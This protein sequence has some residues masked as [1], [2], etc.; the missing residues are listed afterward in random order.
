VRLTSLTLEQFRNY[1]SLS[2]ELA[3]SR[4]HL[5][6]G[7][8]GSGKTNVLEAV[9]ILSIA[10]SCRGR[11]DDEIATWGSTHYRVR[12]GIMADDGKTGTLEAVSELA[13]RRRKAFFRNDAKAS[14][15]SIVGHL[16]TVIF[17]PQDLILFS[18]S[19]GDRRRFLDQLLCQVSPEYLA[20]FSAYQ[21]LLQQR[22]ALLRR[23]A[24]GEEAEDALVPWDRELARHGGA[25]TRT[26]LELVETLN[27]SL[28]D[29][30][31]SLGESWPD[32][33]IVYERKGT[34]RDQSAM[35]AEL[36]EL[37]SRHRRRDLA[38][39]STGVGPHRED[40]QLIADGRQLPSFASRGQ[41]RAAVLALL[42]LEVSYLELRRG[43]RP[44]ILLDDALSE[45]DDAHQKALMGALKSYQVLLTSA[46]MPPSLP[47]D[48]TA[49]TVENGT[50]RPR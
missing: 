50:V 1:P 40:W 33:R 22:N 35:E 9:S 37:L 11:E 6:C 10:K 15:S 17:L 2:M 47:S 46:R 20:D 41:E 32:A 48:L 49:W 18:G 38:L 21:K 23:I 24:D 28:V 26:R 34:E 30:L 13:P 5:F 27:L 29:E 4:M 39:L 19:P 36:V 44:V 31:S 14:V 8:N 25:L 7:E 42:L 16:P 12:G 45:L 3:G 43:E